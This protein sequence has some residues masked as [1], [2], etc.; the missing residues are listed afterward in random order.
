MLL[1]TKEE[2]YLMWGP[3][4]AA[5]MDRAALHRF[6]KSWEFGRRKKSI[7]WCCLISGYCF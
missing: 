5:R 3:V 7:R 6:Y 4:C 2:Q 1:Q